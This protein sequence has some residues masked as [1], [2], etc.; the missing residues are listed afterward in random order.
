[1]RLSL[2]NV[3]GFNFGAVND[4]FAGVEL[5][6][7]N[8][9]GMS[10]VFNGTCTVVV[11]HRSAVCVSSAGVGVGLTCGLFVGGQRSSNV[12]SFACGSHAPVLRFRRSARAAPA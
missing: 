5:V 1:M 7:N 11:A 8:S 6:Y 4:A 2:F 10:N 9:V 12:L 3:S